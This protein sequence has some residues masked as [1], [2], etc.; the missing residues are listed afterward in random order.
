[1]RTQQGRQQR[2]NTGKKVPSH[3]D[4]IPPTRIRS[5]GAHDTCPLA[6]NGFV[7]GER[8]VAVSLM[9]DCALPGDCR[10]LTIIQTILRDIFR[11]AI[12]AHYLL[13]SCLLDDLD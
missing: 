8:S 13:L 4:L 7:N 12:V 11:S 6:V 3:S 5:T 10:A 9:N 1:M 2:R